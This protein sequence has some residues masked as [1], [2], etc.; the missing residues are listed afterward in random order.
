MIYLSPITATNAIVSFN[1]IFFISIF[2]EVNKFLL[3]MRL[4]GIHNRYRL[5]CLLSI[6]LFKFKDL[7]LSKLNTLAY[8]CVR[9]HY[10][11]LLLII[12]IYKSCRFGIA[13]IYSLFPCPSSLTLALILIEGRRL[14]VIIIV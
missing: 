9:N 7:V 13:M 12:T 1:I 10:I 5:F 14:N 3:G 8:L 6:H 11:G 2:F 4:W